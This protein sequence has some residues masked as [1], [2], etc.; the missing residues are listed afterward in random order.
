MYKHMLKQRQILMEKCYNWQEDAEML[1][2]K[3]YLSSTMIQAEVESI[4]ESVTGDTRT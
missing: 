2:P 4:V 1:R 3:Q